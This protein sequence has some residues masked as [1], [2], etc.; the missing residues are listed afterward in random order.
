[1]SKDR[2][3]RSTEDFLLKYDLNNIETEWSAPTEFPD[4]RRYKAISID[5]ETRDPGIKDKGP[6]WATK[7]GEII[8][9]AVAAGDFH[10]YYP[11]RHANG[12]NLDVNMVLGWLKE[13]V[14]HPDSLK[15]FHNASYDVGWLGV[16]DIEVKGTIIDTMIA[17]PLIDENRLRYNLD[18]LAR[19]YLGLRKDEK[20]LRTAAAEWHV[21]PK[22]EMYKL[23]ARF[24]GAY[25]EQD[26][27]VTLKLWD[28]FRRLLD[29]EA[30]WDIFDLETRVLP[31][32]IDMRR[33]G[34]P[35]DID[36]MEQA[37][38]KLKT[39]ASDIRAEIKR[40]TG[41]EVEPWSAA[42]VKSVFDELG[43]EHP[44]TGLGDPSFVKDFLKEHP[45]EV[46]RL[47][48]SLREADKADTS[49]AGK[50]LELQHNGRIHCEFHPLRSDDG[51]T[52]TGRFSCSNPNLQQLPARVPE[53]KALIR[54]CFVGEEGEQFGSF[55]YAGQ[56]PRILTHFAASMPGR[57]RHASVDSL[58][59]EYKAGRGDLHQSVADLAGLTRKQAKAINLGIMY[60]MGKSKLA[61]ELHVSVEEAGE[62]LDKHERLVPFVKGM[63]REAT[64]RAD[65]YGKI[66]TILGRACH[67]DM[68]EP[69]AWGQHKPLPLEEAEREY[70]TVGRGIKRAFTYKALN[71]LI[72]G[73]AA[74]QTK[75]AVAQCYE[76]GHLPL[77]QVH[78]ELCFSIHS[79]AQAREIK[80]IMEQ[81]VQMKVPSAVD[82]DVKANWGLCD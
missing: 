71:K 40:R 81:G 18:S 8:G 78:D 33:R 54:G 32:V 35:I 17:A 60:G 14:S 67:F 21:D 15:V 75:L 80:E 39:L 28:H 70:G 9:V 50:L 43:L 61:N 46:P 77:M 66:R 19:D 36:R 59:E 38:G 30:L 65:K 1:M 23:P 82:M 44:L 58:V 16:E 57:L 24:V 7:D 25:A 4:L 34:V 51:G 69:A 31:A 63:A 53:I 49:F 29:E 3:D 20:V 74:D 68:W 64:K 6:G 72:Q 2:Y 55:D 52:V 76:A 12:P 73:S 45:H 56:E 11:I 27:V 48:N 47:I 5:L 79:D 26:A 10:G 62:L 37:S 41:I 13:Q 42:S 22:A